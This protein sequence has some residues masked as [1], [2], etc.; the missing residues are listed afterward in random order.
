MLRYFGKT[1]DTK[2]DKPV[3]DNGSTGL[4]NHAMF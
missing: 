2:D 1:K 3:L 4:G